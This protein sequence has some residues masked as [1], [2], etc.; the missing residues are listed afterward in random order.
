NELNKRVRRRERVIFRVARGSRFFC[1]MSKGRLNSR[2]NGE[3]ERERERESRESKVLLLL[4]V[5]K[6]SANITSSISVS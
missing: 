2:I 4:L 6:S 1:F 3:R 5:F